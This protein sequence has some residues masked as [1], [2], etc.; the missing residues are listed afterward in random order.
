MPPIKR[1]SDASGK[2]WGASPL[3]KLDILALAAHRDDVEQ[4][5]GGTLLRMAQHGMVTGILDLTRGEAGTRGTAVERGVEAERAA[6]LLAVQ[7]RGN[8]G[9]PDGQLELSWDAKRRIAEVI[10][11]TQPRILLAPFPHARH[12]DHAVSGRLGFEAAF[13]AGLQNLAVAADA[14]GAFRPHTVLYASLYANERPTLVVDITDQFEARLQSLLAYHSQYS[15]QTAGKEIFPPHQD[16][17]ARVEALARHFGMMV[18]VKYGEPFISPTPLRVGDL[19]AIECD[20]F[21]VGGIIT[22]F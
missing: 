20:T 5:C 12:P 4:T 22:P 16:I 13:V 17:A 11:A 10:R 3:R 18:G 9:L 14:G 2:K 6:A 1:T 15:D 7:W 8:L 19:R 21:T